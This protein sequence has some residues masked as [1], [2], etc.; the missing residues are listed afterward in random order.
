MNPMEL[1]QMIQKSAN[2]Q[3]AVLNLLETQMGNTPMGKNLL[4]LAKNGRSADI[5]QIVRNMMKAQGRDFDTEFAN[6]K[7]MFGF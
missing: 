4:E 3:T 1:I 7:K 5:E 6:F 2:P